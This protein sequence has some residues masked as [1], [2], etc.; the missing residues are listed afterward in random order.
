MT[1]TAIA[2]DWLKSIGL[3]GWCA[4]AILLFIL[5]SWA[6]AGAYVMFYSG[7]A[8]GC[9]FLRTTLALRRTLVQA[10]AEPSM[11]SK[12]HVLPP[13]NGFMRVETPS[14]A[15][16]EPYNP[17]GSEVIAQLAEIQ[18][19]YSSFARLPARP[20]DVVLDCGANVGTFTR[21]ALIRGA[22]LVVAIE[23]VPKNLECLRRNLQPYIASKRVIVVPKGVWNKE[24]VLII[25]ESDSSSAEDSFVRTKES[26][27]GP[28]LPLTTIDKIVSDLQLDRVDFIKMDIE[29]AEPNALRGAQHTLS[30]FRPRLE[31]EV[32]GNRSE[33]LNI[34]RSAW[35]YR[36]ECLTCAADVQ[37]K[38]IAPVLISLEP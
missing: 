26:H 15:F 31:V 23:P 36:L 27:D 29:G 8:P 11:T 38:T 34:A 4:L 13:E 9:S 12:S 35:P 24:D 30:R 3:L 21:E 19:K 17:K 37:K 25:H 16:W 28:T 6:R 10:A 14:G 1:R 20:G 22:R 5:T 18:G 7:P 33:I 2:K 32:S